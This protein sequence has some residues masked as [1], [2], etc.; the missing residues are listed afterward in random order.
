MDI[1]PTQTFDPPIITV[2]QLKATLHRFSHHLDMRHFIHLPTGADPAAF[3]PAN[4][5]PDCKLCICGWALALAGYKPYPSPAD[6]N[7]M[8]FF[9]HVEAHIITTAE[10]LGITLKTAG[11]LFYLSGWPLPLLIDYDD[12][13]E[14]DHY[15]QLANIMCQAIDHFI[16]EQPTL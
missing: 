10:L 7:S 16:P 15:G 1:N 5:P 6:P 9:D 12:A 14:G 3:D 11:K 2:E 13:T 8:V 4:P